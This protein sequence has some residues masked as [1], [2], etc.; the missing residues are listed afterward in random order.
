[1]LILIV[2]QKRKSKKS[3]TYK[4]MS[5]CFKVE[6]IFWIEVV[7][8]IYLLY[9]PAE[10]R[11]IGWCSNRSPVCCCTSVL[12]LCCLLRALI[13]WLF[14]CHQDHQNHSGFQFGTL[15]ITEMQPHTEHSYIK[16]SRSRLAISSTHASHHLAFSSASGTRRLLTAVKFL[17][18]ARRAT[19]PAQRIL[20]NDVGVFIW[21]IVL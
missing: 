11:W 14:R 4:K 10:W 15:D 5:W 16:S 12:H 3:T 1:M 21:W 6:A 13:A 7:N 19:C 9:L 8:S 2:S 18:T 20:C 17:L